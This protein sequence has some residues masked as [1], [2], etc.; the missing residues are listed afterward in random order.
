M[1]TAQNKNISFNIKASW[2]HNSKY[3][4]Y[5]FSEVSVFCL[6]LSCFLLILVRSLPL[7]LSLYFRCGRGTATRWNTSTS[8]ALLMTCMFGNLTHL[9]EHK[10]CGCLPATV[11]ISIQH[12]YKMGHCNIRSSWCLVLGPLLLLHISI[13]YIQPSIVSANVCLLWWLSLLLHI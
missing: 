7:L 5:L 1:I 4:L 8:C 11:M 10:T 12:P 6:L 3:S 9:C 13:I 2:Q